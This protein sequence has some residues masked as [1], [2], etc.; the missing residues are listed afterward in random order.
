RMHIPPGELRAFK[1]VVQGLSGVGLAI[2]LVSTLG[3]PEPKALRLRTDTTVPHSFRPEQLGRYVE[4]T[5]F[6]PAGAANEGRHLQIFFATT[7]DSSIAG[8][9]AS[10]NEY[11]WGPST[12]TTTDAWMA[13]WTTGTFGYTWRVLEW[14]ELFEV[15]NLTAA[16]GGASPVLDEIAQERGRPRQSSEGDEQVRSRLAR[17]NNPPSPLGALRAAVNVLAAYGFGLPDVRIY[18]LGEP[19]PESID[20]YA[21]NF[22][23]ALGMIS[24]LHVSDM[25]TPDTPDG[26]ASA[27]PDYSTLSPFFNPGLALLE[28]GAARWIA[29]VR[30]D[31]PGAMPSGTVA[32]V[33]RLL[34]AALKAAKPPGCI[35]LLYRLP[36][37]SYP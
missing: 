35:V 21:D 1:E 31:P 14:N 12:D 11:A 25:S 7:T 3:P 19:G 2:D 37:W 30:W 5:N 17:R 28:P 24:D 22:P 16:T 26:M 10:E 29:V 36:Q 13:P 6:A 15:E 23:A 34:Y 20:P 32:Q 27:A 18:E 8:P 4:L 9:Q 33:R